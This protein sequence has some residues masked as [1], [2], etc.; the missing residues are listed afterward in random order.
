MLRGSLLSLN[1]VSTP[2]RSSARQALGVT[3][4]RQPGR[5]GPADQVLEPLLYLQVIQP[6]ALLS[7][8]HRKQRME[9]SVFDVALRG[10][11]SDYKCLDQGKTLPESLDYNVCWLQTAAGEVDSETGIPPPLLCLQIKDF[12]NGPGRRNSLLIKTFC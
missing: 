2:S 6:S 1:S 4:V 3:I 12:L 10:V 7:C 9:I 8:H 5:R 11:A